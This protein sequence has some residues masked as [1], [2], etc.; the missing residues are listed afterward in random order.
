MIVISYGEFSCCLNCKHRRRWS[1]GKS[2]G[3]YCRMKTTGRRPELTQSMIGLVCT[4]AEP[5]EK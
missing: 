2:H 4:L 1:T 3:A 5:K